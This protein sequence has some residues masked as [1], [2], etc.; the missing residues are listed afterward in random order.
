MTV[1]APA[2]ITPTTTPVSAAEALTLLAD[3]LSPRRFERLIARGL[4]ASMDSEGEELPP[5][6][7]AAVAKWS[8]THYPE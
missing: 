4:D 7:L 2:Q 5:H 6:V 8:A 3:Y 1:L